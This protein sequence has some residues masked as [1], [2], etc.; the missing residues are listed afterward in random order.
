MRDPAVLAV[1]KRVELVGV[2][3]LNDSKNGWSAKVEVRL[4]DGRTL[5]HH[6]PAARG[7]NFNP[8]TREEENAKALDLLAPVLGKK[9]AAALIEAVWNVEKFKNARALGALCRA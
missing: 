7:S 1:K 5:G 3:E 6:T 2:P 9:R 4:R 8:M